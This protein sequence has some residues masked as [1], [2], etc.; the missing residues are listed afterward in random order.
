MLGLAMAIAGAA[1]GGPEGLAKPTFVEQL[2]QKIAF[3]IA[4]QVVTQAGRN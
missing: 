2:T 1:L 3:D 4:N